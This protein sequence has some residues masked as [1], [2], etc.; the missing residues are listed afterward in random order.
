MG[1]CKN[2]LNEM[3]ISSIN[4]YITWNNNFEKQRNNSF[5]S[6]CT[7]VCKDGLPINFPFDRLQNTT[8]F[9]VNPFDTYSN[10]F[11]KK[12]KKGICVLFVSFELTNNRLRITVS[13]KSIKSIKK[14]NINIG[15]SDWG[16]YL[17]EY[18]CEI[19][20]WKLKETKYEGI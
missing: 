10:S 15:L 19:Q 18:L 8:F 16:V 3:I 17:Y 4:S 2:Q 1:Q 6:Y 14:K 13:N 12:L 7:Y 20:E 5:N 11:K 9:T